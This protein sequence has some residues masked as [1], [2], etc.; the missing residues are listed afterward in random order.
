MFHH[1]NII[2]IQEIAF[3][4]YK[5]TTYIARSR[6]LGANLFTD[7]NFG[8]QRESPPPPGKKIV[9]PSPPPPLPSVFYPENRFPVTGYQN[10]IDKRD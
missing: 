10:L 7:A 4:G 5:L 9:A 6:H 8:V 2:M 1:M 3:E